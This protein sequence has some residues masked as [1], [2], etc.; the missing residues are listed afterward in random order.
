[1]IGLSHWAWNK[2]MIG[3]F[4]QKQHLHVSPREAYACSKD[5]IYYKLPYDR[6]WRFE[7]HII[8]SITNINIDLKAKNKVNFKNGQL[9]NFREWIVAQHNTKTILL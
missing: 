2:M 1:M 9:T 6:L 5:I 3:Q 4:K 8:P 7:M